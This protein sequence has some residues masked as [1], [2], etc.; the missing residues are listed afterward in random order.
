SSKTY[1]TNNGEGRSEMNLAA[2]MGAKNTTPMINIGRMNEPQYSV[3][4]DNELKQ[5]SLN[6]IDTALINN[7][8][9]K[10][11]VTKLGNET[12]SGYNCTHARL[13]ITTGSGLFK[14]SSTEDIWTSEDVPGYN[15]VKKA[16]IQQNMTPAMM[17]ALNDAGC[18]GMFVKMTTGDKHYSMTMQ[19]TKAEVQSFPSA[20]FKIPSG[21]SESKNNLMI[22]G[23]MQAGQKQ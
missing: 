3:T 10:Y 20:L 13:K 19:L 12:V 5:Y 11:A 1:F 18:G 6:V 16:T 14:S 23:L 21:Y 17:K 2:M 22:G 8:L 9:Q 15:L 4:I 7:H